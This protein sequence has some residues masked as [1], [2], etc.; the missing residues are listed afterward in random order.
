MELNN[1]NLEIEKL[2]KK[3]DEILLRNDS[4]ANKKEFDEICLRLQTLREERY[5]KN[6]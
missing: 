4:K 1:L 2:N 3:I 5:Y 6:D